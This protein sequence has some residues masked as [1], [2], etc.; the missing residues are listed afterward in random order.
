MFVWVCVGACTYACV[1]MVCAHIHVC[2]YAC[3]HMCMQETEV[4]SISDDYFESERGRERDRDELC[5]LI[6]VCK[7]LRLHLSATIN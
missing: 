5:A 4:A 6:C 7:K 1:H 2:T 3:A